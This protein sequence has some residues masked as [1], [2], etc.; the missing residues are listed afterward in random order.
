MI[1]LDN[2]VNQQLWGNIKEQYNEKEHFQRANA[3]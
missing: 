2:I 3:P 1:S